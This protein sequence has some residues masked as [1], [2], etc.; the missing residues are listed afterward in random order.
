[1]NR[2]IRVWAMISVFSVCLACGSLCG[3]GQQA[4]TDLDLAMRS[5]PVTRV[6]TNKSLPQDTMPVYRK[7]GEVVHLSPDIGWNSPSAAEEG[8][9]LFVLKQ[10]L[11]YCQYADARQ[12]LLYETSVRSARRSGARV[13]GHANHEV[14]KEG[15]AI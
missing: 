8:M 10:A 15:R 4:A 7:W 1:M 2:A 13:L 14:P 9:R 12:V 3:G 5:L 11:D 6:I